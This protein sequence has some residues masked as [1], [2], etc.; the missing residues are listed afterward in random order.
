MK[1]CVVAS[2]DVI[3]G[4]YFTDL[5]N[6]PE[7]LR[8]TWDS[9]QAADVFSKIGRECGRERF[10]RIVLTGMGGSFFGLHPMSMEVAASGW[11][12][13]MV[14]TSELI[15]YYPELLTPST[16]VVAISQSGKSAETIR[17]LEMNA[18]RA[19]VIGVT[20][21]ADSP[22]A[23]EADF[24][25]MTAAGDE[26]TVSCKTYVTAQMALRVLAA[27]LSGADAEARLREAETTPEAFREYLGRWKEHVDELTG[28]LRGVR[29]VFL[30]GRGGS[31]AAAQTGALTIK[32]STHV[33]AEGMSSAALRH[34]PF[35]MLKEGIFVGVFAG[36]A[37]TRE[38][39]ERMVKDVSG[40]P[41]RAVLFA[42]DAQGVCR[43][44]QIP[45]SARPIVE[46]L[47]VQM[48]TLALAALAGREAG[49]FERAT[50][51][52]AVE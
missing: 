31:L 1:E 35:E 39:N 34:G 17:L 20:N 29:D 16:L 9:L 38:L 46:V 11:T 4:R 18:R 23:R 8:A 42:D 32:E 36:G 33:H 14:E 47:P 7:A 49:K 44:P 22:L 21:W 12:P 28:L 30:V 6:Q 19:K 25:V 43:L 3:Q 52:T 37:K 2:N 10:E 48:M 41:A 40:T 5:M 24:A 26:Y 13:M 45:D 51:V 50:K 27:L 15:H